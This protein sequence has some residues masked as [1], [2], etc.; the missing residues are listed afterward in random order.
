MAI[1][2]CNKE[3]SGIIFFLLIMQGTFLKK[4]HLDSILA[5]KT[6]RQLISPTKI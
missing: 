1:Y 3:E 2:L 6:Y 4:R 5:S